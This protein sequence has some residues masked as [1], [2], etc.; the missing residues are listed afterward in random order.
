[1][2]GKLSFNVSGVTRPRAII[3]C[4]FG[5][6]TAVTLASF[7]NIL[8]PQIAA[9]Y[10]VMLLDNGKNSMGIKNAVT[11]ILFMFILGQVGLFLG[12]FIQDYMLIS[13]LLICLITYWTFRLVK[14]PF[15]VRMLFLMLTLLLS[16]L[17]LS[18][19]PL[20]DL[21]LNNLL[22]NLSLAIVVSE[23]SF[24]LFPET[25]INKELSKKDHTAAG[26][27]NNYDV[28]KLGINGLVVLM[29]VTLFFFYLQL[30]EYLLTYIYII[31][32]GLDPTIYKS[33]KGPEMLLANLL[34][35]L[36]GILVY[37]LLTVNPSF[38]FYI[39][40]V[41]IVGLFFC[42]KIFG[43]GKNAAFYPQAYRAFFLVIA[44]VYNS[45][46]TAASSL[47]GRVVGIIVALIY[48][49]LAYKM[50]TFFNNPEISNN[51]KA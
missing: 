34:G 15:V 5:A 39:I 42:Y 50:V 8:T 21:I 37:N 24:L 19:E 41:L 11:S 27:E 10:A 43:T 30:N 16:F 28:N 17:S 47:S 13:I 40:L 22:V 33:K 38:V 46:D 32:L 2:L 1:M 49:I 12:N 9:I 36:V 23:I 6:T 20:G 44:I 4:V 31:I 29:P 35:G 48:V 7:L 3:R 51:E 18:A 25:P 26:V 45:T 14:V